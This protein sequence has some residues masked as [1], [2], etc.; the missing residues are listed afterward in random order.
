MCHETTLMTNEQLSL[1]LVGS[2]AGTAEVCLT[3]ESPLT[4][5]A[6]TPQSGW[7]FP[8]IDPCSLHAQHS[9]F[10]SI[11][12]VPHP[13]SNLLLSQVL[14]L[15]TQ[16]T[17][18]SKDMS[19]VHFLH[20]P[21]CGWIPTLNVTETPFRCCGSHWT[22]Q[23]GSRPFLGS[24]VS[25]AVLTSVTLHA[26]LWEEHLSLINVSPAWGRKLLG[27]FCFSM[28]SSGLTGIIQDKYG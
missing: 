28:S 10:F 13:R 18:T 17:L 15:H 26:S 20:P 7:L 19:K 12:P 16:L 11:F 8:I 23:Q 2:W 9:I 14:C 6:L 25:P 22:S 21:S 5:W 4:K 3:Y 24:F 27:S 1:S